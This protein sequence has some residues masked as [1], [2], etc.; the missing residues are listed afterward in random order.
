MKIIEVVLLAEENR[1][2]VRCSKHRAFAGNE[3]DLPL[4]WIEDR[5]YF[6]SNTLAKIS[7][8]KF[9]HLHMDNINED[10]IP[11]FAK[12]VVVQRE[13][14]FDLS[15][16]HQRPGPTALPS[17]GL[18]SPGAV[19]VE[20]PPGSLDGSGEHTGINSVGFSYPQP[21]YRVDTIG[22]SAEFPTLQPTPPPDMDKLYFPVFPSLVN[23]Q[24]GTASPSLPTWN[25]E[26]LPLPQHQLH[27]PHQQQQQY[28]QTMHLQH[29]YH[30]QDYQHQQ[31]YDSS[32][33]GGST[34]YE[35]GN[36]A[37]EPSTYAQH[38]QQFQQPRA[39]VVKF[40]CD[41]PGCKQ[42]V[43]YFQVF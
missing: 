42:E 33:V 14:S 2:R 4:P 35:A 19:Q 15:S 9:S 6:F 20:T 24:F 21:E 30:Q 16:L 23:S 13:T 26:S 22:D 11:A 32:Y 3:H 10:G 43:C 39:S 1:Y 27:Y 34:S 25:T 41:V 28:P 37:V 18:S 5:G 36:Y 17:T 38:V 7:R 8:Q 31:A 29:D 40:V 12:K